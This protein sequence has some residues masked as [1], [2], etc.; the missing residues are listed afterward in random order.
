MTEYDNMSFHFKAR[1]GTIP[2]SFK[3][4]V[5]ENGLTPETG[6]IIHFYLESAYY[7]P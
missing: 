3:L 2:L 4:S 1:G 5:T 6:H 7:L